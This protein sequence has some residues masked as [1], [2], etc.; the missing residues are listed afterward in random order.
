MARPPT[1]LCGSKLGVHWIDRQ[2]GTL[3]QAPAPAARH[4]APAHPGH[5]KKA[6]PHHRHAAAQ[7]LPTT[8]NAVERQLLHQ[9]QVAGVT[10]TTEQAMFLAQVAH[11]SSG[12]TQLRE[13]LHYSAARL[14]QVFPKKFK[15]AADAQA[16]AQ[17][18]EDAIAERLYGHRKQLG[19]TEDGDGALYRGRGYIQLTG[20][21]NYAAA[22]KALDL[23][24]IKHPELAEQP[25]VA[26][27]VAVWFWTRN[28]KLRQAG[29]KGDVS[30][31]TKIINGG[32]IGLTDRANRFA[33]Y[34]KLVPQAQQPAVLLPDVGVLP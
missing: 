20:R 34:Q 8:L 5:P 1:P 28:A 16:V 33:R 26:G 2:T 17:Q 29:A 32:L 4:A 3:T 13:N 18:G 22:G 15:S 25:D 14:Q 27:R 10:S 12:F 6:K 21:S 11:E 7:P 30:R 23:D 9:L 19:N 24:L 31:S